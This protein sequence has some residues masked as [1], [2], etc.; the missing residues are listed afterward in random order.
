M[1]DLHPLPQKFIDEAVCSGSEIKVRDGFVRML[2]RIAIKNA[3]VN[4]AREAYRYMADLRVSVRYK[5]MVIT[6]LSCCGSTSNLP[7]GKVLVRAD[8]ISRGRG[9]G[10]Y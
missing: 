9:Y 3:V 1:T 7:F 2:A 6:A 10:Q 8:G 5:V 4:F